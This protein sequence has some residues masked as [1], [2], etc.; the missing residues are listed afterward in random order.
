MLF[1][2]NMD[3]LIHFRFYRRANLQESSR[4]RTS[5]LFLLR[6]S[7]FLQSATNVE[8]FLLKRKEIGNYFLLKRKVS[9]LYLILAVSATCISEESIY[10]EKQMA[11]FLPSREEEIFLDC[12][13][14]SLFQSSNSSSS[15]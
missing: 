11:S 9:V 13:P 1:L 7:R 2:G 4:R 10:V 6:Q 14:I 8:S 12:V 3:K 15:N 5:C